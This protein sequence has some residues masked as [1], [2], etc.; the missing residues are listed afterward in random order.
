MIFGS[1][2]EPSM[3]NECSGKFVSQSMHAGNKRTPNES[4]IRT[5]FQYQNPNEHVLHNQQIMMKSQS[6]QANICFTGNN[7]AHI[8]FMSHAHNAFVKKSHLPVH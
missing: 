8:D 5:S 4:F 6:Q 1:T 7:N 3:M 2:N